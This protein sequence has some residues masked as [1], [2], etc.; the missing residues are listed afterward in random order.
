MVSSRVCVLTGVLLAMISGPGLAGDVTDIVINEFMASNGSTVR[1][2]QRQYDDW[3]ELYNSSDTAVDVGG[4]YLTDDLTRPTRWRIPDNDVRLTT[5]GP[6]GFLLVWADSDVGD[7]GLHADFGLSASGEEIGLYHTDGFT[8]I[9]SVNYGTQVTDVSYGRFPDGQA[10]WR[11]MSKP[12]PEAANAEAYLGF[13]EEV[14]VSRDHGFYD[15]PFTVTLTNVIETLLPAAFLR[16]SGSEGLSGQG[17][18]PTL[19]TPNNCNFVL[20]RHSLRLIFSI[21]ECLSAFDCDGKGLVAIQ[22]SRLSL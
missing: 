21:C 19:V 2:A 10:E 12:T 4:A 6:H 9:D 17:C 16:D 11:F 1:D 14:S 13:V 3:I 20:N 8:L 15:E 22:R 18:C 7:A 5:I